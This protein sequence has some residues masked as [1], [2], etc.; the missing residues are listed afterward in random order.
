MRTLLLLLCLAPGLA[1][2][3]V[4][5]TDTP[6]RGALRIT[7]DPRVELWDERFLA[8]NRARLGAPLTGDTV[9]AAAIPAVARL[10]QDV[11]TA[12][13]VP[14]FIASLGKGLLSVRAERRTTPLTAEFGVT[15]RLSVG[16]TVPLV[17][18]ATRVGLRLDP[19]G[20]SVGASPR[21]LGTP[22]AD[23]DYAG[24][25]AEF[26][27]AL[28]QLDANIASS[29][30]GCPSSPQCAQAQAFSA[31][32]HGVRDALNR[33]VYGAGS[34]G[35][36]PFLPLEGSDGGTGIAANL[37]R[38]QQELATSYGVAGFTRSFLLPTDPLDAASFA[39]FLADPVVGFGAS[40]FGAT[41]QRLRYFPGDAEVTARYRILA[42]PTYAAAAALVWRLPTGHLDS[43]HDLL[44]VPTGD[45]QT[46]LEAQLVQELIVGRRLW[47]NLAV[48]AARQEPGM[49]IRRVAPA[50]AFLV[51]RAATAR[52]DWD[53]GDYVAADFAPLYRFTERFA[54]GVTLGFWSRQRDR[55][56]FATTQDSLDLAARLGAP[57][58][59]S[60]LDGE[61]AERRLRVGGAVTYVGPGVEAGLSVERT[62][63][64]ATGLVPAAT[65]F[66]I[67]IR[68][69]R[70][71]LPAAL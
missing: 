58:P 61:T 49:R 62:V 7:F 4:P 32:A 24:F 67:V 5:R 52:L 71:L 30:Y 68:T 46:D 6:R 18:V 29:A 56:T 65:V 66:R 60:L 8:G 48:R 20:A 63:S 14:G 1:A 27:A 41:P 31:D 19:A 2:Q 38:I 43:P 45:H 21:V 13:A 53:P 36:A 9:G 23:A 3:A 47:L 59:A 16:V 64:A 54:A 10:E 51:P 44:D 40:P 17:R 22:G 15:G 11:R 26:D 34:A 69:S 37:T 70:Q 35:T 39:G 33:S 12:A 55:Y 50:A 28:G 25:F 57:T 42:G